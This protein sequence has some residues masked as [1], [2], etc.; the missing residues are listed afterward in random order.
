[1][2]ASWYSTS[3]ANIGTYTI[4]ITG[5][6]KAA[7]NW[8]STTSFLLTVTGTCQG[9]TQN[10]LISPTIST[11]TTL[12]YAVGNIASSWNFSIF[13]VTGSKYC[14]EENLVYQVT[15]IPTATDTSVTFITTNTTGVSW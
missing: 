8:I 12:P 3:N 5:T 11:I 10:I 2:S 15:V 7:Q 13:S 9:A 6:I 14:A 1:M 4:S